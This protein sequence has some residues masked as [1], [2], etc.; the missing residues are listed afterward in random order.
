MAAFMVTKGA[1][2]RLGPLRTFGISLGFTR[3]FEGFTL[4]FEMKKGW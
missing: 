4:G 3:G 2:E 1:G